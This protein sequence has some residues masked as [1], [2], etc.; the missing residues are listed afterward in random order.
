[1]KIF[2]I[3]TVSAVCSLSTGAAFGQAAAPK[4]EVKK[5]A[6]A[7]PAAAKPA[8]AAGK[9]TALDKPTL[10]A[11]LRHMNLWIPQVQVTIDDPKPSP[12]PGY[13]EVDVHLSFQGGALDEVY[14]VS[15]DGQNVVRGTVH[16]IN[17]SPFQA[18]MDKLKNDLQPSFGTPGAPVVITLFSDFQCP[19]CKEEAKTLRE[20]L[21]KDKKY[22]DKVR[23][24]FRD[25]PLDSIHPWSRPA[26]IAG[27]CVYRQ[28]PSAFWDYHDYVFENQ[29]SINPGNLESKVMDFA[30]AKNLDSIQLKRCMDS[31]ATEGEV[32]KSVEL[33]RSL[34]IA[35]TPTA[36][37]NGRRIQAALPWDT[38]KQ[39][40]DYEIDH[41]AKTG[42]GGETC[43]EVK[44][45]S[46][47]P[48]NK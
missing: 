43:C 17:Q 8:A 7:K 4:P 47:L 28:N 6:P 26:A 19:N 29:Q 44:V 21:A 12:M 23:V 10:E 24:Y 45:P 20:F 11:Y 35:S 15:K 31:K 1:M 27:R 9:K 37:I 36:F 22:T 41:Q 2:S 3:L 25:F 30:K 13:S 42:Q 5:A 46:I 18:E 38:L 32:N 33:G 34:Q 39:I 16:N 14:Y 40:L 48:P